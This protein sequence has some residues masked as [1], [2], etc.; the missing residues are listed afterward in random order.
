M[1]QHKAQLKKQQKRG[2]DFKKIKRKIGRKLPPPKNTT[3]TEV[4]SKAIILP[5]QTLVSEKTGLAVSKKGLTLKELLQQTSHHNAKVRRDALTGIRDIF[6]NHPTELKLHKLT[7]I[8]KLRERM[9]DEDKIVRETLFQLLKAVV[10]PACK[11]DSQGTFISLMMAYV[12]NAMTHLSID[13]RLMAFK[14]FDLVVQHYP[15]AF[16][17]Y[18]DK[19]IQHYKE[20]LQ[21]NQFNLH[22]KGKLKSVL[23]GLAYCLSL[24]PCNNNDNNI[25]SNSSTERRI[26]HAY[27]SE[28]QE[29]RSG[30]SVTAKELKTLLPVLVSGIQDFMPSVLTMESQSFDCLLSIL[31]S[32]DVIVKFFVYGKGNRGD[33]DVLQIILKKLFGVFPLIPTHQSSEKGDSRYFMLNVIISEIFFCLVDWSAPP[34]VFLDKFLV[35]IVDALFEKAGKAF[36]QK[37]SLSLVR[38]IPKLIIQVDNTWKS[39]ILQAFTEAFKKCEPESLMKLACLS[40]IEEMLFPKNCSVSP[41]TSDSEIMDFQISWIR[42]I[43]MLLTLLGDKSP[44]ASKAVLLLQLHLGQ[45]GT[46]SQEFDNMQYSLRDFYSAHPVNDGDISYGPFMKFDKEIQELSICCLYYFSFVDPS[47]LQSIAACCLCYDLEPSILFRFMEVSNCAYRAGHIQIT[48]YISFLI[49]LLSRYQVS[50]GKQFSLFFFES[51]KSKSGLFRSVMSAV[52]SYLPQI[53][54]DHLVL[55]MLEEAVVDQIAHK[56]PLPLENMCALLRMIVTLDSKPTKLSEPSISKLGNTVPRYLI[57]VVSSLGEEDIVS[58]ANRTSRSR[59]YILPCFLLFHRSKTIFNGVLNVMPS[60][61]SGSSFDGQNGH[62]TVDQSTRIVTA[63]RVLLL[64]HEDVTVR[65]MLSHYKN[66]IDSILQ[67]I[68]RIKSDEGYKLKIEEKHKIKCAYDRL[69][70]VLGR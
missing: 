39:H 57:C 48:D 36:F 20:I 4:K 9:S 31:K 23:A 26:L 14:F 49:T 62:D 68:A 42:E 7:V 63:V 41:Y 50:S 34:S 2:V 1:V 17:M 11:E 45:C 47:L 53:G 29:D 51:G 38:F 37:H 35:F 52:C 12:F 64:M 32:I 30:F 40:A 27:E 25:L 21:K 18:A 15:L 19:I 59:Y 46:F 33:Q 61:I 69:K 43:P 58:G 10:F 24:L 44:S 54:D 3:N 22:D 70:N 65:E 13:V 5:E 6:Q 67:S 66:E 56:P 8:E 60:F 55:K 28:V 16:S